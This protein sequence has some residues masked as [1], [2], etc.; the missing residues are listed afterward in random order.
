M[1]Y[2]VGESGSHG[3]NGYPVVDDKGKVHG[4]HDSKA[5]AS[6][7]IYAINQS[8]GDIKSDTW[9]DFGSDRTKATQLINPF[10]D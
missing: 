10:V 5:R 1:P 4:C 3:C 7:Q 9:S 6:A 2:H 8:E